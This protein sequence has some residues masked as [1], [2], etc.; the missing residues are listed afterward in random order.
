[1]DALVQRFQV[2]L[3][4]IIRSLESDLLHKMDAQITAPQMFMLYL[5]E[6]KGPCKLTQLA[7]EMEVKPSAVTVMIDR[8]ENSGFVKRAH[9]TVDR[10]SVLVEVTPAGH[11]VLDKAMR[12]RNQ[13]IG[14]YLWSRLEADEIRM[15]TELLEKMMN[16]DPLRADSTMD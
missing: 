2:A 11:L 5:I 9:G 13:I 4:S 12:E 1:M 7:D 15:L 14:S 8:L 16:V 6:R 10:R 3:Q